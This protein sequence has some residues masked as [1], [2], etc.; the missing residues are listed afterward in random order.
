[1]SELPEE[2]RT[3]L[4]S[5]QLVMSCLAIA[6]GG[7]LLGLQ[8]DGNGDLVGTGYP[9]LGVGAVV[10][11]AAVLFANWRHPEVPRD[12]VTGLSAACGFLGLA[13]V[14]SG[15]LAPGGGWMFFEVL[16]LVVLLSRAAARSEALTRGT[17]A[18]LSLMLLFRLWISYQG[19][20]HRWEVVSIDVPIVSS[21]PFDFLAPIQSVSLGE[22]SPRELGFP[23]AGLDFA[24]SLALWASGFVLCVVGLAWRARAALEHENDRIHETIHELP[25]AIAAL[26]ERLLPEDQWSQLGLH[27]LSDRML[28]KKIEQLVAARVAARRELERALHSRELLAATNPGGF[29]GDIYRALTEPDAE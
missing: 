12:V 15:V 22:F 29:V 13:F 7:L 28:R 9:A 27:G 17:I 3:T 1:M 11:L 23:P 25:P 5:K 19:S 6:A 4:A 10:A 16:L 2:R 20:Q 18:V 8:V 26:V 14:V 21:I 24:P